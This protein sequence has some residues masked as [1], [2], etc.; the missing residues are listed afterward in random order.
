MSNHFTFTL[1]LLAMSA[2][3]ASPAVAD[4]NVNLGSGPLSGF[5]TRFVEMDVTE[6]MIPPGSAMVSFEFGMDYVSIGGIEWSSDMGFWIN[7]AD[8]NPSVQIGGYNIT[9]ADIQ[10][11][12]WSFYGLPFTGYYEDAQDLYQTGNGTWRFSIGNAWTGGGPIQY[13][14]VLVTVIIGGQI[15]CGDAPGAC[16]EPH[17]TPGCEDLVCCQA[18]CAFDPGCCDVAWDAVCAAS[19][20]KICGIY[21]Y[22]CPDGGPPNNC[23][24]NATPINP[25]DVLPFD[26]T[27]ADPVAPVSDCQFGLSL[28]KDVWFQYCAEKDGAVS[29]IGCDQTEYDQM[30]RAYDIGDGTY[31]PDTLPERE[32]ACGDDT[33]GI[34]GGPSKVTCAVV[35]GNCYLFGVG[36]FGDASGSGT[37]TLEFNPAVTC[38]DP[39]AGSCCIVNPEGLGYC[40]DGSCCD[41]V[42]SLDPTCCE[43][44]WDLLC[45]NLAFANCPN[46]CDGGNN[47]DCAA[48]SEMQL[49]LN[50]FSTYA[51]TTGLPQ[52][53]PA[54]C[55][56]TG[57]STI[58]N[59]RWYFYDSL[60]DG[61]L[62]F[63][64]CQAEGGTG[65]F[66]SKLAIWVGD[67]C[68]SL[69]N[70]GCND[71]ACVI[72]PLLSQVTIVQAECGIRYYIQI[73]GYTQ[74]AFGAGELAINCD[75]KICDNPNPADL[76]SDGVVNGA[77][78]A[79]V[80]SCWG[81]VTEPACAAADFQDDGIVDGADLTI[82]LSAWTN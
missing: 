29:L 54:E 63:S 25:G 49:G 48:A 31:D 14:N 2:P 81:P 9:F 26:T 74:N 34:T 13:N 39:A 62:K 35:A 60:C 16:D 27:T 76:N 82:V 75:G 68:G 47:D 69:T 72:N 44:A 67:D 78:L 1:V 38:G 55:T 59:D 5:Q 79:I 71:D 43:A 17:P 11:P 36:G 7:D 50:P 77:D 37:V 73:G 56:F 80:L 52:P 41:A 23:P 70:V 42:C 24:T 10:G 33:C 8:D 53:P 28:G 57:Q 30:M 20:I 19:A 66:D 32:I 21:Q 40:S 22:S 12:D 64:M 3:L 15:L 4:F 18:V 58:H 46:V 51:A 45:V 6:E 65:N 61:N